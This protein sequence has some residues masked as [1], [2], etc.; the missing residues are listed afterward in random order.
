MTSRMPVPTKCTICRL[1]L[2]LLCIS[3]TQRVT[4]WPLAPA[5]AQQGLLLTLLPMGKLLLARHVGQ[6]ENDIPHAK[7]V[8]ERRVKIRTSTNKMLS[9][10]TA[11]HGIM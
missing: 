9:S 2:R 1:W 3:S 10:N 8:I 5:E 11:L 7:A 6:E 4:L